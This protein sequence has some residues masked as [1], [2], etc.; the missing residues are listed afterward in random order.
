M[1]ILLAFRAEESPIVLAQG[2]K[3]DLEKL[4][5][6]K[7]SFLPEDE[8]EKRSRELESLLTKAGIVSWYDNCGYLEFG[9]YD[10]YV[11]PLP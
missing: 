10:L 2:E 11:I 1:H 4:A 6:F 3:K 8:V 5:D 9:C 7:D